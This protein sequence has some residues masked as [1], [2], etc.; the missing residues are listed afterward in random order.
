MNLINQILISYEI[1]I[2]NQKLT[3]KTILSYTREL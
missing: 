3:Y 2:I 1:Q